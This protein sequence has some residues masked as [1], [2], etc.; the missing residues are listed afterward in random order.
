MFHPN[1]PRV[2]FGGGCQLEG[3]HMRQCERVAGLGGAGVISKGR[4]RKV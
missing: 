1:L 4:E 3:F 2:G